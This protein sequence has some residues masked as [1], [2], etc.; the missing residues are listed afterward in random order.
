MAR[1]GVRKLLTVFMA[2]IAAKEFLK[3]LHFIREVIE[4]SKPLTSFDTDKD[5]KE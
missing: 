2:V 4:D 1:S 5:P 3:I